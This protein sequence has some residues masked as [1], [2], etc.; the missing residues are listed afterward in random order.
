MSNN[1]IEKVIKVAKNEVGYLEKNL[2]A[3]FMIKLL[4]QDKIIILN[5]PMN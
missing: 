1:A 4:M 2:I 5:M 3:N